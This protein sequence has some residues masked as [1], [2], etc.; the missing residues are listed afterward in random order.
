MSGKRLESGWGILLPCA[1]VSL[2]AMM[3]LSFTQWRL[4][5]GIALMATLGMLYHKRLRHY[6]LLPSG[7]ALAGGLAAILVNFTAH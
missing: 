1:I 3:E 6:L 5:M 4:L 2:M 7:V